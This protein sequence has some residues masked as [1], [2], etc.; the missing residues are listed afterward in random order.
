MCRTRGFVLKRS[1]V[2][3]F[4]YVDPQQNKVY[5]SVAF[6][7][8]QKEQAAQFIRDTPTHPLAK[9]LH[10]IRMMVA[11]QERKLTD[12]EK[13]VLKTCAEVL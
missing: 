2:L 8:S 9:A 3:K 4:F 11:C 10:D 12:A 13:F 5:P 7:D 6:K 1:R